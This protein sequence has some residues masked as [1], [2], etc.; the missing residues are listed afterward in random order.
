MRPATPA[1]PSRLL[2]LLAAIGLACT[3]F[4]AF[5]DSAVERVKQ[6]GTLVAGV[7]HVV[8]PYKAGTKFRTAEGVETTLAE[9]LAT[10]LQAKASTVRFDP[11]KPGQLLAA[12]KADVVLAALSESDPLHRSATVVPTGYAAGPMAIMRTDTDI[13]TW[14]QLK[15]RKVCVSRD[16]RYAGMPAA[17]FG[18]IEKIYNAPA[19]S[20]LALRI[21]ACDAAVH[22]ST[23]LEE[24]IKLPEW[25]K[26]SARLPVGPRSALAFVVPAGDAA[27]VAFLRQVAGDWRASGY[28]P[29][30]TSQMV[31]HIAFEVYLDQDVPDCH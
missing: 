20:L 28:L 3:S 23:M 27:T 21:G 26:F 16:S 18:A 31:R 8:P 29:R 19:E 12:G 30:L 10:R 24:L 2:P 15:G 17:T 22:D 4:T 1:T 25:K 5:A 6:R 13:K 9:D 11:A 14:Q 7:S